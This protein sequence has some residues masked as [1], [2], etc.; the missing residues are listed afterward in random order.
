[1]VDF[2]NGEII[3]ISVFFIMLI[4]S[5]FKKKEGPQKGPSFCI[6]SFFENGGGLVS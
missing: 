3:L 4:R 6:Y 1:M 2:V 5:I